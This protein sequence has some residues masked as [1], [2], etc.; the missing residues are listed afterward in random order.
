MK[1]PTASPG[2]TQ[3]QRIAQSY[4]DAFAPALRAPATW[5]CVAILL[6]AAAYLAF[7]GDSGALLVALG[8]SVGTGVF[9]LLTIP[10]TPDVAVS[11]WLGASG[12]GGS[13]W[14]D[15]VQ[16]GLV[17]LLILLI[18]QSL[19]A[20]FR[21]LPAWLATVPVWTGLLSAVYNVQAS[22][23]VPPNELAVPL[24]YFVVPFATLLLLGAR[25]GE[26]GFARGYR[27]WRVA[28][29]WSVLPLVLVV[30]ALAQGQWTLPSLLRRTVQTTLN[31]G[32]FEEF[33]FRGALRTRLARLLG[34]SW[35]IVLSGLAFGLLHMATTAVSQTHGNLVA[36]AAIGLLQQGIGGIGFA[37]VVCRTRNLLATSIIHVIS[38]V[39]FG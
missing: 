28:A 5:V 25:P 16:V 17:L 30:V 21:L 33:L 27:P 1:P 11:P 29:L 24:V 39:A 20:S 7:G 10:L 12:S 35:G 8:T 6:L 9:V 22:L 3:R 31:S 36:G 37:I 14:K 26:L 32:P 34:N 19:L 15:W 23:G 13:R 2:T 38:N 4:R 18:Y